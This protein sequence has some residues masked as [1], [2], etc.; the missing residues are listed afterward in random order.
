MFQLL[1]VPAINRNFYLFKR[2]EVFESVNITNLVLSK[3]LSLER[4]SRKMPPGKKPPG[5]LPPGNWPPGKLPPE[6]LFY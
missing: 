2:T 3:L 4:V 6:K 5:K 1:S